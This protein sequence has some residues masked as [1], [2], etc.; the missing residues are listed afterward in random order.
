MRLQQLDLNLLVVFE[1][2]YRERNLT[3]VAEQLNIT[4]P[5]V[6]NALNR[7]RDRLN[8]PLF[9]RA[10]QRM[11]P[12]PVAE[13]MIAGVREGLGQLL[14]SIESPA[15]FNPAESAKTVAFAMNDLAES[16]VLGPLLQQV[17]RLAPKMTIT[18]FNLAR[19]EVA[20]ELAS[21]RLDFAVDVP[22]LPMA[23]LC[24]QALMD[25]P[26]VCAMRPD[27]PALA[28]E[29]GLPQYL[30]L[31]H[32]HVSSRRTGFGHVDHTLNLMGQV[33]NIQLRVQHYLVA[34]DIV[35]D[36]DLVWT[37][38]A[39]L[40]ERFGLAL[41]PLPFELL[42]LQL[43]LIW[44]RRSQDSASSQWLRELLFQS[45]LNTRGRALS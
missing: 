19:R 23:D 2:I 28:A 8:D 40:G 4:Q 16:L 45:A 31:R 10:H 25:E 34:P 21:G 33:R 38:P 36:T 18:S 41:R 37:L 32:I 20:I 6:S 44:H 13:S 11:V 9:E 7:L 30:A 1:A 26:Y 43:H 3:R 17:S 27:H 15:L 5:A 42:P 24:H 39:A 14:A 22:A 35:R 29:W 12:T